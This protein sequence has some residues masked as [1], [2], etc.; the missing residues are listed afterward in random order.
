M[1]TE[2]PTAEDTLYKHVTIQPSLRHLVL[3]A[4]EEYASI[5]TKA[6]EDRIITL[7]KLADTA[8][9]ML[10]TEETTLDFKFV[11]KPSKDY[12]ALMIEFLSLYN[13]LHTP[14]VGVETKE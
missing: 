9:Q 12:E 2:T 13:S 4:M 3:T 14:P 10:Q 1:K 11:N 8:Y 7:N 5:K 6:L